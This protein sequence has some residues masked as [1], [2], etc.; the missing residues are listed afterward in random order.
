MMIMIL[1]S[2]SSTAAFAAEGR[3]VALIWVRRMQ[4]YES[5]TGKNSRYLYLITAISGGG[6]LPV[7]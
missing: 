6:K 1:C 3:Y 7:V 5:T 4:R 2:V